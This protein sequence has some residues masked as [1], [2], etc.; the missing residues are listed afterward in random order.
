MTTEEKIKVMLAYIDGKTIIM[1]SGAEMV[2]ITRNKPFEP[3]WNFED[4]TYS[5]KPEYVSGDY[6]RTKFGLENMLAE[7]YQVNE[8]WLYVTRNGK[9]FRVEHNQTIKW[10]PKDGEKIA[11]I[12]DGDVITT[13]YKGSNTYCK[14]FKTIPYFG[15][16]LSQYLEKK[17]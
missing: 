1:N 6:V 12:H 16:D 10:I 8:K 3:N 11:L 4:N 15:Q 17:K 13:K 14:D 7:V 2:E 5:I 9:N